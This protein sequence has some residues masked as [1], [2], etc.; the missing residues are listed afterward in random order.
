MQ[1]DFILNP[2]RRASAQ[3]F[4]AL[5]E[6]RIPM[7]LVRNSRARRYVLRLRPD[8]S[9][10][11]T[12]P[13]GGSVAEARAFAERNSGWVELELNRLSAR[14]TRPNQWLAGTQILF[15]GEMVTI[16]AGVNGESGFVRKGYPLGYY[17][18]IPGA[19]FRRRLAQ[20]PA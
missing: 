20:S 10:R 5:N 16:E 15:R 7:I 17:T 1:F 14:Q 19:F 8:G 11:V 13:R 12:I 6:R 2:F 4:L 18:T 9:A 3:D